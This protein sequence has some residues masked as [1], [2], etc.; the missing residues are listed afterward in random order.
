VDIG[1]PGS[2]SASESSAT[3]HVRKLGCGGAI[4]QHVR[5][6]KSL[7]DKVSLPAPE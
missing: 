5:D 4:V 2:S 6:R 7:V 1:W 3:D